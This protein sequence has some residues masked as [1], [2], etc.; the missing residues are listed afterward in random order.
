MVLNTNSGFSVVVPGKSKS[1]WSVRVSWV[2]PRLI[3]PCTMDSGVA[4]ESLEKLLWV[5]WSIS[6]IVCCLSCRSCRTK[7]KHTKYCLENTLCTISCGW[8]LGAIPPINFIS[9]SNISEGIY[10]MPSDTNK[11]LYLQLDDVYE[12]GNLFG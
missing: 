6:I 10:R 8:F 3:A 1:I 4:S 2:K 11:F 9:Y 5:C 7:K 12:A